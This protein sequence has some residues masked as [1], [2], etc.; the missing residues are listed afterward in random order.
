VRIQPYDRDY[1]R[2]LI[3]A[4]IGAVAMLVVHS[5]LGG[6]KWAL[7]LVG[8]GLVGGLAY[9]TAFL[10]FGLTRSEKGAV[11]RLLHRTSST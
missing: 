7:D 1:A 2:L 10:L 3:P 5:I 4:A 11:I 9:Y 8:T 6:P